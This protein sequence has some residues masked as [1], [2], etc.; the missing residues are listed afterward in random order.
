MSICVDLPSMDYDLIT[1]YGRHCKERSEERRPL[2]HGLQGH[3][4]QARVSSHCQNPFA[5]LVSK[6]NAGEDSGEAYGFNRLQRRFEFCTECDYSGTSR[7]L[8]GINQQ[9]SP[10]ILSRASF[11]TP[12]AV[13]VHE[14]WHRRDEQDI[15]Q[16]L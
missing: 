3:R 11:Q 7:I 10:G 8:M 16:A 4:E 12:E 14:Q 2:A 6:K 5:A 1:L 13:M 9:I 15:P